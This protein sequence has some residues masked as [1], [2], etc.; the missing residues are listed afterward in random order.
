ML[1]S[2][3]RLCRVERSETRHRNGASSTADWVPPEK[4]LLDVEPPGQRHCV[5]DKCRFNGLPFRKL[6]FP[7]S[8]RLTGCG[9]EVSMRLW[10]DT[11]PFWR[12]EGPD[13]PVSSPGRRDR[14]H[15]HGRLPA[16][17]SAEL[18][19]LC[20][21]L[22]PRPNRSPLQP[23]LTHTDLGLCG[24][25]CSHTLPGPGGRAITPFGGTQLFSQVYPL[26]ASC[27]PHVPGL[28]RSSCRARLPASLSCCGMPG[29]VVECARG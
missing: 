21:S 28:R 16:P 14:C 9:F 3:H 1:P 23:S 12:K 10:A 5:L 8:R 6:A 11:A 20:L 2:T 29:A 7:R 19:S 24:S 13:L 17:S 25:K 22:V 27:W 26:S 18:S 15:H 4:R